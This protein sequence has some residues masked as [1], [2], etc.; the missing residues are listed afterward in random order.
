LSWLSAEVFV[1]YIWG[2]CRILS[3][4]K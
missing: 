3:F 4:V 1:W 2:T